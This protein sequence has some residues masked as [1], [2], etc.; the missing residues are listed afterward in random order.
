MAIYMYIS[1]SFRLTCPLTQTHETAAFLFFF[2]C[3]IIKCPIK[4]NWEQLYINAEKRDAFSVMLS[5]FALDDFYISETNLVL[6][7]KGT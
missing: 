2:L 7:L 3:N 5:L 6:F 1:F 4:R